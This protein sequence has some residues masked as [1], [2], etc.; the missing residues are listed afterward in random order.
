MTAARSYVYLLEH[1]YEKECGCDEH[2]F[3]GLFA[4]RR[5][6]TEIKRRLLKKPGFRRYPRNFYL[7]KHLVGKY[8][9]ET[10]FVSMLPPK[11]RN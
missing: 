3:I 4:T 5:E 2:K 1:C 11:R 8:E 7:P 6:A 9:W 10:G